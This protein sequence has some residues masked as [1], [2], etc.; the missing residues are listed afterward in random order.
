[1][2]KD[3]IKLLMTT[4]DLAGGGAEREFCNLLAG[5]DR[6]RFDIHVCLWRA[7]YAYDCPS[8]LE[9][10]VLD[11]TKAWHVFRTVR[12][13]ARLVDRLRPDVVF[14]M[15]HYPNLVTGTA[16]RVSK[17]KPRWV[18]RAV[19]DP[20]WSLAG[21]KRPWGKMVMRRADRVLGCSRG[22]RDSL[23]QWLGLDEA[24]AG[25]MAK[26]EAGEA[27]GELGVRTGSIHTRQIRLQYAEFVATPGVVSRQSL[28]NRRRPTT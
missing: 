6:E 15:L 1:M 23:V 28:G 9:L 14:S 25:V 7:D 13:M 12:R 10:T 24:R 17:H 4:A 21:A 5:L 26:H 3:R 2:K 11:K 16:L 20:K 22:V 19:N 8:D 18:C 27:A